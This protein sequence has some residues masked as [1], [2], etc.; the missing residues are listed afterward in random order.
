MKKYVIVSKRKNL[1]NN[2]CNVIRKNYPASDIVRADNLK[3]GFQ[4]LNGFEDSGI[5]LT[6]AEISAILEGENEN[7][8]SALSEAPVMKGNTIEEVGYVKRYIRRHLRDDLSLE[9]L[10]KKVNLSSNYLCVMFRRVE[11]TSIRQF[12]EDERVEMAAYMLSTENLPSF[13]IAKKV[14]YRHSSY[15]S[16]VFRKHYGMTPRDYRKT[17]G[18]LA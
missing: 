11:G 2:M 5:L 6:D 10:A 14:G 4:I 17:R 13:E 3:D 8:V 12:V 7:A 16:K 18:A 9:A 1:Y 15:F